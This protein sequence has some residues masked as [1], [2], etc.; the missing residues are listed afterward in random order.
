MSGRWQHA[1]LVPVSESVANVRF[2]KVMHAGCVAHEH[3][4]LHQSGDSAIGVDPRGDAPGA[5][6]R[7]GA[8]QADTAEWLFERTDEWKSDRYAPVKRV[9]LNE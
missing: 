1:R 9:L 8:R 3:A 7:S 6:R 2:V 5:P 4:R